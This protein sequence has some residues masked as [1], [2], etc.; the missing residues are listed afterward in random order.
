MGIA[1]G[2]A[3]SERQA[4]ER[5]CDAVRSWR[6][7]ARRVVTAFSCFAILL[8]PLGLLNRDRVFPC[9]LSA[10]ESVTKF[11]EQIKPSRVGDPSPRLP[12]CVQ[13][14]RSALSGT[15]DIGNAGWTLQ[16]WKI[17]AVKIARHR[18]T[19]RRSS[20]RRSL[21]AINGPSSGGAGRAL[22][23][24]RRDWWNWLN[25]S[26]PRLLHPHGQSAF[27]AA[28]AGAGGAEGAMSG[29]A[30]HFLKRRT[31]CLRSDRRFPA[32]HVRSIPTIRS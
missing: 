14:G 18:P 28:P 20:P 6:G 27:R 24:P 32:Q 15:I 9:S 10:L 19:R 26:S 17:T 8:L 7:N 25:W 4:G 29:T 13:R 11:V 2:W 22:L 16:W 21:L 31:L 23:K 5:V 1:D 3:A 12:R 30:Y